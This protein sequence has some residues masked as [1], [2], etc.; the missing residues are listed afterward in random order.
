V[1]AIFKTRRQAR[2]TQGRQPVLRVHHSKPV[3]AWLGE[4]KREIEVFYLPSYSP[5]RFA[6]K[7]H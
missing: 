3:K 1:L 4:H 2:G 7:Y 6:G 5:R